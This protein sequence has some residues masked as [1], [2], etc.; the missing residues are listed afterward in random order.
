MATD[1]FD[2][3]F[4]VTAALE[5]GGVEYALVG[6]LAVAVH[7]APRATTDIDLLV[8]PDDAEEAVVIAKRTGF[9]FEALPHQFND[10]MRLRRVTRIDAGE[11]L[12]V[13]FMLADPPLQPAW[14][15]RE[16]YDAGDG[17]TLWVVGR[18]ELIAMKV[19]AGRAK[20]LADIER[21]QE[22]DR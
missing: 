13:D 3:L 6:G 21:L 19:Q 18:E 20:D 4:E 8:A 16:R 10:G 2:A 11:S 22:I 5:R 17:R 12:T 1:L 15:S 9:Q 14:H 7:G